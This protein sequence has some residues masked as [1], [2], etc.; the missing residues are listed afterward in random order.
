[1]VTDGHAVR[2]KHEGRTELF[3]QAPRDL[4]IAVR[5]VTTAEGSYITGS[6]T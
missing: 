2:V 4:G 1:M 5:P 6:A 3:Q